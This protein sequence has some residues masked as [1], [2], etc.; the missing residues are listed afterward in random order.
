M[1]TGSLSI[2]VLAAYY[3]LLRGQSRI[4]RTIA[5]TIPQPI[6]VMFG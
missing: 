1:A 4:A 2:G 3:A 5:Q 6:H